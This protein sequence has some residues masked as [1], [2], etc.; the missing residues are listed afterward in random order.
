[1]AVTGQT[2]ETVGEGGAPTIV[3]GEPLSPAEVRH[4]KSLEGRIAKGL[5]TFREVGVALMEIRDSRLYRAS[6]E[7]FED[8][9][10]ERWQLGRDRAYQFI[11]AAEVIKAIGDDPAL[12]N[13]AQARE[14]VEVMHNSPDQV[15]VIWQRVKDAGVPVTAPLI[16]RVVREVM[17]PEAPKAPTPTEQLMDSI[18]RT[19]TLAL[20]WAASK[21]RKAD[22]LLVTGALDQ[23]DEVL[24]RR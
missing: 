17:E 5:Q 11:G 14:L 22:R 2:I 16:R 23:L 10:R 9:C 8:Y 1:V 7:S 12:A 24:G 19:K 21:P 15:K 6:F 3:A 18:R 13:E 4:L 20:R